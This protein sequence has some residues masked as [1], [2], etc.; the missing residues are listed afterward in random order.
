MGKNYHLTFAVVFAVLA[1]L[2]IYMGLATFT[3]F[4]VINLLIGGYIGVRSYQEYQ[5]YLG[6]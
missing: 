2:N 6:K 4:S 1:V 5:T 3:A